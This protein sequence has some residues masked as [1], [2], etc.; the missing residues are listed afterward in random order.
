MEHVGLHYEGKEPTNPEA[1]IEE[2]VDLR[3]WAVNEGIVKDFGEK[4]FWLVGSEPVA[5]GNAHRKR[6]AEDEMEV[7]MGLAVTTS[8]PAASKYK[9]T[10]PSPIKRAPKEYDTS[11]P[12]STT[13]SSSSGSVSTGYDKALDNQPPTTRYEVRYINYKPT[14]ILYANACHTWNAADWNIFYQPIRVRA[15]A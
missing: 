2:D 1:T 12:T 6:R 3:D 5:G 14:K 13:C 15:R 11:P 4:G 7:N 8:V 10:P 9:L